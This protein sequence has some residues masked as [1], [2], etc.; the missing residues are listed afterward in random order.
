MCELVS[1]SRSRGTKKVR[2]QESKK[3][4][5]KVKKQMNEETISQII[6]LTTSYSQKNKILED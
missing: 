5:E 3:T 1:K 4:N 6:L 2:K